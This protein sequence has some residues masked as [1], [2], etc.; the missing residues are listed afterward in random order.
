MRIE[1]FFFF[2]ELQYLYFF[3]YEKRRRF[4]DNVIEKVTLD[5]LFY[6][7]FKTER[8]RERRTRQR[9][10]QDESR[11]SIVSAEFYRE[12]GS[13]LSLFSGARVAAPYGDSFPCIFALGYS[14]VRNLK[15]RKA[16]RGQ[17]ERGRKDNKLRIRSN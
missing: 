2:I 13:F 10:K 9:G 17:S 6:F 14:R 11:R 8:E 1:N 5:E 3:F 12:R 16:G 7:S 15:S 4:L